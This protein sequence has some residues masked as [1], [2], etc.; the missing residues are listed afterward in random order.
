MKTDV[1]NRK[2]SINMSNLFRI[3]DWLFTKLFFN[4]SF[5]LSV[6]YFTR[7]SFESILET[8]ALTTTYILSIGAFGYF[9][10]DWFDSKTDRLSGKSNMT[11]RLSFPIKLLLS[12]FLVS[13]GVFPF[14]LVASEISVYF[15]LLVLQVVLLFVYSAPFIRL[16][17]NILGLFADALFSFVLPAL[18]SLSIAFRYVEVSL[19]KNHS[20]IALVVWLFL[21]GLR[22]ILVHQYKDYENDLLSRTKTFTI[23]FGK[24]IALMLIRVILYVEVVSF[25]ILALLLPAHLGIAVIISLSLFIVFELF[26]NYKKNLVFKSIFDIVS[27]LNV[28]YNNYIFAGIAFLMCIQISFL[29]VFT[30]LIFLVIVRNKIYFLFRRFYY[31]IILVL[32]FK[33]IG[34]VSKIRSLFQTKKDIYPIHFDKK[35]IICR[36]PFTSVRLCL[37]GNMQICCANKDFVIGK[38][39]QDS[40]HKA[41]FGDKI[42]ILRESIL[43]KDFSNGCGECL[44]QIE[45]GNISNIRAASYAHLPI[46]KNGYPS[47]IEFEID[48]TCNLECIMCNPLASSA[49]NKNCHFTGHFENPYKQSGFIDD[50]TKFMPYL[51]KA[52]FI[53]GEPFLIPAYYDIWEKML[54]VNK[55]IVINISTNGTI[56]NEKIKIILNKGFFDIT[57]SLDSINK[58]TYE[59]IRKNAHFEDVIKNIEFFK[60]YCLQKKTYFSIYVC[61]MVTNAYEIPELIKQFNKENIPVYFNTVIFPHNLSICNLN[62]EKISDIIDFYK[63]NGMGDD[64]ENTNRFNDLINQLKSWKIASVERQNFLKTLE[65]LN[66]SELLMH[67]L[68]KA[69]IYFDN[70]SNSENLKIELRNKINSIFTDKNS[71]TE[72][73]FLKFILTLSINDTTQLFL[74]NSKEHIEYYIAQY[75]NFE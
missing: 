60:N 21:I 12:I 59:K 62:P 16:K 41:W 38:Y 30:L 23:Q 4:F 35:K 45:M 26:I 57:L 1:N 10:N 56:L 46:N 3:N 17:S 13:V 48:N 52:S 20:V 14:Y 63:E 70:C 19:L 50:I 29:Y 75:F 22:G 67:Y 49:I 6:F 9:V 65:G 43:S 31:S 34:T 58:N 55:N 44:S 18:I 39:P 25:I 68:S 2:V 33:I 72:F 42:K 32:Y 47:L 64:N 73:R 53:G 24:K 28:F 40:L 71:N 7:P 15:Y 36:A 61:P 74:N 37:N 54:A 11:Y 66:Y 69:N 8:I 27:K 5:L 51:K